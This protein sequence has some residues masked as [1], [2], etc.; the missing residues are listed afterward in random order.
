MTP[1]VII[2]AD[3]ADGGPLPALAIGDDLYV[4]NEAS[5]AGFTGPVPGSAADPGL[6][7]RP[8]GRWRF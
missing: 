3:G 8:A 4:K 5:P 6:L 2:H 7:H 1:R